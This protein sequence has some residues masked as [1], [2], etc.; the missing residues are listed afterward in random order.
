[1]QSFVPA[2]YNG[3]G[4]FLSANASVLFDKNAKVIGAVES[5]RDITEFKRLEAQLHQA[6]KLEAIGTLAGGIAHDF[7][8][9]L[10]GIVGFAEMVREDTTPH[11]PQ[12][13][14]L[15]LVLRGAHRG[16][17]LIRQILTF[18][19]RTDHEQKP[20]ALGNIVKEGLKLLRPVLPT[21]IEIR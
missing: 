1:A 16:R 5:L 3:K 9:I 18:S 12:Y 15:G 11:T 8:N 19:R 21:T 20:V 7:N 10:T 14:R 17:D 2:L 6:Q 4:A 13:R